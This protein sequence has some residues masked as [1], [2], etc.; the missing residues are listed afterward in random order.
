M[1]KSGIRAPISVDAAF[2][3][4]PIHG[5]RVVDGVVTRDEEEAFDWLGVELG[6]EMLLMGPPLS[7]SDKIEE[8]EA[9]LSCSQRGGGRCSCTRYLSIDREGGDLMREQLLLYDL[10]FREE[11]SWSVS[12]LV[13]HSERLGDLSLR[14]RLYSRSLHDLEMLACQH[15]YD[16]I[17]RYGCW[18]GECIVKLLPTLKYSATEEYTLEM[19]LDE[20]LRHLQSPLIDAVQEDIYRQIVAI[21]GVYANFSAGEPSRVEQDRLIDLEKELIYLR[22]ELKEYCFSLRIHL[23]NIYESIQAIAKLH[24]ELLRFFTI[25]RLM[26]KLIDLCNLPFHK[27]GAKNLLLA[28][29]DRELGLSS[30]LTSGVRGEGVLFGFALRASMSAHYSHESLEDL[31]EVVLHWDRYCQLLHRHTLL[32]GLYI[33]KHKP[34]ALAYSLREW[35]YLFL[36]N[37]DDSF[38]LGEGAELQGDYLSLFPPFLR[39]EGEKGRLF[40]EIDRETFIAKGFAERYGTA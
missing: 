30:L 26:I 40:L 2:S 24:P 28:L 10:A 21:E 8:V 3:S 17:L 38:Y 27:W 19:R 15:N 6:E 31:A 9:L 12:H 37:V 20:T 36:Q 5:Y 1:F 14:K 16:G 18:F 33:P 32:E 4:P 25:T 7:S 11:K 29:L 23:V 35:L 13:I 39:G 22:E 34:L